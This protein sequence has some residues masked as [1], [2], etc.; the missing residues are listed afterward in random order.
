MIKIDTVLSVCALMHSIGIV[1]TLHAIV[2]PGPVKQGD[3]AFVTSTSH[4]WVRGYDTS[5]H[6]KKIPATK[7]NCD[8]MG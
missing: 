4:E 2:V 3:P 7:K 1:P 6:A 5:R 8:A